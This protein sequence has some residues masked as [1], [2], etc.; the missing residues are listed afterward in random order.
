[1]SHWLHP[2]M[3]D[4]GIEIRRIPSGFPSESVLSR[5]KTYGMVR[6]T[7]DFGSRIPAGIGMDSESWDIHREWRLLPEF[8]RM[9]LFNH[10][11]T[12]NTCK[13]KAKLL[14]LS[15]A[16]Y[17]RRKN[18]ALDALAERILTRQPMY[19]LEK[20]K[21]RLDSVIV[22]MVKLPITKANGLA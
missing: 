13:A 8:D 22:S 14:K 17:F 1:M 7:G 19:R 12:S 5:L 18:Q 9:L 6:I 21:K 16:T 2:L 11:V 3:I 10:Y 4:W 15:E 20:L